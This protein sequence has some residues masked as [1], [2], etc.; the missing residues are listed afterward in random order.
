MQTFLGSIMVTYNLFNIIKSL[1]NQ[2]F[3]I[4]SIINCLTLNTVHLSTSLLNVL[5]SAFTNLLLQ[6]V[7]SYFAG[8]LNIGPIFPLTSLSSFKF[9]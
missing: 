9:K 8:G 1:E 4:G 7:S 5:I 6:L 2:S 3:N